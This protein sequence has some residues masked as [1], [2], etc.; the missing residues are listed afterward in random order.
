MKD[1]LLDVLGPILMIL[2][3]AIIGASVISGVEKAHHCE[4]TK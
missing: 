3:L 1:L 2:G 4:E